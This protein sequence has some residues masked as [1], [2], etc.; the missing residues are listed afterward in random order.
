M[1]KLLLTILLLLT[2]CS[3]AYYRGQP[4]ERGPGSWLVCPKSHLSLQTEGTSLSPAASSTSSSISGGDGGSQAECKGRTTI[5]ING[6][7]KE[8]GSEE[9]TIRYSPCV[10]HKSIKLSCTPKHG[11]RPSRNH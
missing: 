2:G 5:K 7:V 9:V 8:V 11:I 3:Q 6:R 1:K 4:V 10:S